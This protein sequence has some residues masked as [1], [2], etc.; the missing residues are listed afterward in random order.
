MVLM[1]HPKGQQLLGGEERYAAAVIDKVI[2]PD[3]VIALH[4]MDY[5]AYQLRRGHLPYFR[6]PSVQLVSS[7]VK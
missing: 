6:N 5:M 1:R 3:D 4:G 7:T 2:S